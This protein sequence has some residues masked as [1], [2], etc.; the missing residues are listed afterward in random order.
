MT[1]GLRERRESRH[2]PADESGPVVYR[3][4]TKLFDLGRDYWVETTAG[5][6]VFQVDGK[7][8]RFREAFTIR[9]AGGEVV[10]TLEE[11]VA[12]LR[13]TMTIGRPGRPTATMPSREL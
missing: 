10:A 12:H 6:T 8:V 4:R 2:A 5:R 9:D 11:R 7:A 1:M 3:M 13:D